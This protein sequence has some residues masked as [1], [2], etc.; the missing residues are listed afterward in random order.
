MLLRQKRGRG[1]SRRPRGD[2][3]GAT[4]WVMLWC[5]S[6]TNKNT[7]A[8][9]VQPCL[10]SCGVQVCST[11]TVGDDEGED[12]AGSCPWAKS[13]EERALGLDRGN[14]ESG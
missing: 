2:S 5:E 4:A 13:G 6:W 3:D 9:V 14:G 11:G 12:H 7:K 8:Y 10:S 1:R